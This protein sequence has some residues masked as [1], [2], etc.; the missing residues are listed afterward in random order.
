MY[1]SLGIVMML[2]LALMVAGCQPKLTPKQTFQKI[3]E[4]SLAQK[5]Y[6]AT[7]EGQ[8]DMTFEGDVPPEAAP[9]M[10]MFKNIK[11][12]GDMQIKDTEKLADLAMH[13]TINLNGLSMDIEL[14][15]DGD[16]MVI[17]YPVLPQYIVV[18][19][20]E[21]IDAANEQSELPVKLDYLT[22]IGDLE[23]LSNTW[24]PGFSAKVLE[25]MDEK[26][27]T[28]L[29]T[30]DFTM[31]G[32]T[33]KSK[34]IQI[35]MTPDMMINMMYAVID[36][37]KESREL[38]DVLKKYD[39]ENTLGT[40]EEYQKTLA[41]GKTEL[42]ADPEIE[43]LKKMMEN[44]QYSYII[45][46][47]KKYN[48]TMM[49]MDMKLDIKDEATALNATMNMKGVYK[50]SYKDVVVTIPV[51]TKENSMS[52]MEMIGGML[53][54]N[55]YEMDGA[56]GDGM[57]AVDSVPINYY[58]DAHIAQ[59]DEVSQII[60]ELPNLEG[61][62]GV[63][64]ATGIEDSLGLVNVYFA[65]TEG[66][67]NLWPAQDL[68]ADYDPRERPWYTN[69]LT[70]DFDVAEVYEDAAVGQYMQTISKTVMVNDV[71]IGV[72]GMDFLVE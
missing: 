46:Y 33:V 11:Y 52:F 34:A 15:F 56:T 16:K 4:N 29:D 17:K 69:A 70:Y 54:T 51:I 27:M 6:S 41:D 48:A 7:F 13:Y 23:N 35:N 30:Y 45:G 40:F 65:S 49:A 57:T 10:E 43:S 19:M 9:Y 12:S 25:S 64:E 20:K 2:V 5:N 26:S 22:L 68:P 59:L 66:K 72:L 32:E 21:M 71:V 8:M 47:D 39:T 63:L 60:S 42:S 24:L 58:L 3:Q 14:Y 28:L 62:D 53:P 67:M 38:Y 55:S 50:M 37:T 31:N 36:Q 44:M 1:R 18:D 61:V